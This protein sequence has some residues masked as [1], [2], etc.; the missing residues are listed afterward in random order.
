MRAFA[1]KLLK[2]WKAPPSRDPIL[3]MW[4]PLSDSR[5]AQTVVSAVTPLLTQ[6]LE[7]D[8]PVRFQVTQ[9]AAEYKINEVEGFLR[10]RLLDVEADAA[11]REGMMMA[12]G[13]LAPDGLRSVVEQMLDDEAPRVRAAARVVFS[14]LDPDAAVPILVEGFRNGT[15]WEQAVGRGGAGTP[16]TQTVRP[17]A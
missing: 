7:S 6:L 9:L 12:L 15:A 16:R 11:E 5:D 2:L 13:V 3:G 4:R 14:Q 10:S 17:G 1:V 8:Q